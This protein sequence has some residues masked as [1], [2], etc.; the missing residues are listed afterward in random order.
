MY[1]YQSNTKLLQK[2]TKRGVSES[3]IAL[4]RRNCLLVSMLVPGEA[5]REQPMLQL[6]S[7]L[8]LGIAQGARPLLGVSLF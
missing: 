7:W 5:R 2:G 4:Y 8:L 3:L 1:A 6:T